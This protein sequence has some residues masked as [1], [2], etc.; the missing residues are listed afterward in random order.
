[1]SLL[2]LPLE[3]QLPIFE[4]S[5]NLHLK[6]VCQNFKTIFDTNL[7]NMADNILYSNIKQSKISKL[8]ANILKNIVDDNKLITNL[9]LKIIPPSNLRT[10]RFVHYFVNPD[11]GTD[12]GTK[13]GLIKKYTGYDT[14]NYKFYTGNND[15]YYY[16]IISQKDFQ[17]DPIKINDIEKVFDKLVQADDF[18]TIL[19]I[20]K[21]YTALDKQPRKVKFYD[22]LKLLCAFHNNFKLYLK[23]IDS[24]GMFRDGGFWFAIL[25]SYQETELLHFIKHQNLEAVIHINPRIKCNSIDIFTNAVKLH[26]NVIF[27]NYFKFDSLNLTNIVNLI[28]CSIKYN[29]LHTFKKI[30]LTPY[31]FN[32]LSMTTCSVVNPDIFRHMHHKRMSYF[33]AI[34]SS[35]QYYDEFKEFMK[36][37]LNSHL[38]RTLVKTTQEYNQTY[39]IEKQ[40]KKEIYKCINR[41]NQYKIKHQCHDYNNH[42][43]LK[44][45]H[46]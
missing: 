40:T 21:K 25:I 29:N 8:P 41:Q 10:N 38:H 20:I 11:F 34:N 44:Y 39:I 22:K 28:N 18:D 2:V 33:E 15:M 35:C 13:I 42:K 32:K 19:K 46:Q 26:A 17:L 1:M 6:G 16:P 14:Y 43:K 36:I 37:L 31:I 7:Y 9:L 23:I 24:S 5:D 30:I 12:E 3:L 27:D 4:W 45:K